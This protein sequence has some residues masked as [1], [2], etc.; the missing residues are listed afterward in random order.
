MKK[1]KS[2]FLLSVQEA[3]RVRHYS[4]RTEQTYLGWIKRYILF[5]N[6]QHPKMIKRK[7]ISCKNA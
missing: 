2:K 4:Y 3:I 6:K 1:F 5:H 7:F